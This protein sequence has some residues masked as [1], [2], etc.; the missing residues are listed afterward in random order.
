[1]VTVSSVKQKMIVK[2]RGILPGFLYLFLLLLTYGC[3][4][5]EPD[6]VSDSGSQTVLLYMVAANNLYD[7]VEAD[8]DEIRQVL[9]QIN[10]GNHRILVF[11]SNP[12][13]TQSLLRMNR[14]GTLTELKTYDNRLYAVDK[15]RMR[16]VL[17]DV[18]KLSP[19]DEYGLILWSHASGW[20]HSS[21]AGATVAPAS[22][23]DDFGHHINIDELAEAI[24]DNLFHFIWM[25]CCYMG[26]IECAWQLR[27]KCRYYVASPTEVMGD[28]MP[29]HLTIPHL[30]NDNGCDIVAAAMQMFG[31]Y[32]SLTGSYRSCTI[33]VIDMQKLPEVAEAA[34]QLYSPF[35]YPD[36][37][38]LQRYDRNLGVPVYDFLQYA[39]RVAKDRDASDLRRAL[40]KAVI[41]KAATP[42]FISITINTNTFSGLG[43]HALTDKLTQQEKYYRTLDW[44]KYLFS[45]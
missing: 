19:A 23:G 42:K 45:N 10:V 37:F 7:N 9:P 26:N 30:L 33:S 31:Y 12:E 22:F 44:Y 14:D 1:V 39:E 4:K 41:Y 40:G 43:T 25:D 21:R 15:V 6:P 18:T 29:Y 28:G 11:L 17:N 24:P 35:K 5:E 2:C 34:K 16:E 38:A 3:V 13:K 20:M 32:N 36:I 27:N 8:L